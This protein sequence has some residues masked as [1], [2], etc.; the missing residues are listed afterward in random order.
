MVIEIWS[1]IMC[2]FCYIGKKQ[3]ELAINQLPYK[4]QITILWRSFELNPQITYIPNKTISQYLAE[5]K[6]M[7]LQEVAT[8]QDRIT[9]Q[10]ASL[11]ITFN[12]ARTPI[13][14]SHHAHKLLHVAQKQ[15]KGNEV[16]ESLFYAYFTEGKNIENIEI[17]NQIAQHHQLDFTPWDQNPYESQELEDEMVQDM[18][19]AH[20]VGV[21]GVP[22]FI[23]DDMYALSGAH[24]SDT[25][26]KVIE[27]VR[28][29]KQNTI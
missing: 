19:Q 29:K 27:T 25:L 7:T 17:L 1:D 13:S 28:I 10:G 12:F 8:M 5:I 24:G 2:P 9:E 21:R 11:G 6:N 22:F 20:Q 18:Y 26:F 16:K 4:D 14:N 15:Q 3:I 23:F